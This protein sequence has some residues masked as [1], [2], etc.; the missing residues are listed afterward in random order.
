M[1][2]PARVVGRIRASVKG[3]VAVSKNEYSVEIEPM[4][5]LDYHWYRIKPCALTDDHLVIDGRKYPIG[6]VRKGT[7]N[8]FWRG[9][10]I[11]AIGFCA[12]Q[13]LLYLVF[14]PLN[15]DKHPDGLMDIFLCVLFIILF[16]FLLWLT[17][18]LA[19]SFRRSKSH[20]VIGGYDC[21][22]EASDG[23][24]IETALKARVAQN[25]Q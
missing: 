14:R 9:F 18:Q 16:F 20:W 19:R 10:Q 25:P 22:I 3:L 5:V 4:F 1:H 21:Y 8:R 23:P 2:F 6:E 24:G 7:G 17:V 11:Y 15:S 12:C 13:S